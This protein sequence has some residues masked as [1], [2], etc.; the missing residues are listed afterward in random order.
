MAAY[1]TLLA[2]FLDVP[3]QFSSVQSLHRLSFKI[4][5]WEKLLVH[6]IFPVKNNVRLC[7]SP[8][9]IYSQK[10]EL[11]IGDRINLSQFQKGLL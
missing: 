4:K 6:F 11:E 9:G 2:S 1:H 8:K 3:V 5:R 7:N 10:Y